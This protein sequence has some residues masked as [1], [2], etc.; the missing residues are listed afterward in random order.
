MVR[1]ITT[2][3]TVYE[4]AELSA[5]AQERA[6][7]VVSG[8]LMNEWWGGHDIARLRETM[9]YELASKLGYPGLGDHGVYGFPGIDGVELYEWSMDGPNYVAARGTL[10][11]DNAPGLPW[12]EGMV[13]VMLTSGGDHTGIDVL[14]G[15]DTEQERVA[16]D[17][18]E[19]AVKD[20]LAAALQAGVEELEYMSSATYARNHIEGG[21]W[22]FLADGQLYEGPT[23][24]PTVTVTDG[25]EVGNET[26]GSTQSRKGAG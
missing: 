21:E 6:V 5:Q 24:G 12:V 19:K 23:D 3:I 10:T 7:Q 1:T 18:M 17:A 8:K 15:W 26:F 22:L 14:P 2:T 16:Y 11:R 4:F 20:A 9:V 25:A 13:E